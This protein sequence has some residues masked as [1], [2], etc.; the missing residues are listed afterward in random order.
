[1]PNTNTGV[2]G[3]MSTNAVYTLRHC[4]I[5]HFTFYCKVKS[6]VLMLLCL[7]NFPLSSL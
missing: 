3:G 2:A 1:L 7:Q 4:F 6:H 5:S